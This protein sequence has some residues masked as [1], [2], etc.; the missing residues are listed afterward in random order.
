[1]AGKAQSRKEQ[2][3]ARL[4]EIRASILAEAS[5]L[6][7]ERQDAVFLGSWSVKDLL[8]HLAGWDYTNMEAASSVMAGK[9]PSF[10]AQHDRDWAKYNA[11]LVAK[12]KR[13][14]LDQL[15]GLV[16]DAQRQLIEFM[17]TVP[18]SAFNKDFG[19]RF[20]GYKVTI[21]RLLEAELKDEQT[22]LQQIVDFL[23]QSK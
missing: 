6:S 23:R 17:Q 18:L 1:M 11:R 4:Q 15:I 2:L 13:D 8:A 19:V 21:Q 10:Y 14:Q 16:K 3:L 9:L 7:A 22:H 12:Y 5:D 20:R